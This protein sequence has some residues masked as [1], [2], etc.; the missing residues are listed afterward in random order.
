VSSEAPEDLGTTA[1]LKGRAPL[2]WWLRENFKLP[3]LGAIAGI[4]VSATVWIWH[5]HTDLVGLEGQLKG[6]AT[7]DQ[8]RELAG[9]L[10]RLTDHLDD[11]DN[12]LERLEANWD[13][14]SGIAADFR[15]PRKRG[16]F[17]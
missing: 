8:I 9:R 2:W 16:G 15:V 10:D 6:L 4:L 7:A 17:R 12:R 13:H 3:S 1:I 11:Q 5:Q 14:A